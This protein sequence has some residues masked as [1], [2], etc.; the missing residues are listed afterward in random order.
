MPFKAELNYFY[1]Y[2][3]DYLREQH[4]VEAERGDHEVLTKPLMEKI[5]DSIL[6]ADCVIADVSGSNPNVFYEVGL[7][8]AFGKPVIFLTQDDPA[9]APVD[10]RQFEFIPYHLAHH[11]EF[12]SNLDNAIQHV[13]VTKY[14]DWYESSLITLREFCRDAGVVYDPA[15]LDE[16]QRRVMRAER[17]ETVPE[18]GSSEEL[19]QFFLPKIIRD[20]TDIKLMN[21][22]TEWLKAKFN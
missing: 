7:A 15:S 20:A 9:S 14:K 3:R 12:L 13:F 21:P 11:K 16:F 18:N 17:R 8:H 2:L 4:G 10:I 19:A 5:R 6:S 1:L 22:I